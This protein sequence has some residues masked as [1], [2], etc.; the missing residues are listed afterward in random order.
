MIPKVS[1]LAVTYSY[2]VF[3]IVLH[4]M[5]RILNIIRTTFDRKN[6]PDSF[7]KTTNIEKLVLLYASNFIEQFKMKY[8]NRRPL[9]L[10]LENECGVQVREKQ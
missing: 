2:S 10:V 4:L 6:V 1:T 3:N 7:V 9:S 8:P 5:Q